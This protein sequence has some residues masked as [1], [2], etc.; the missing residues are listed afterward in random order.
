MVMPA[1][2]LQ[3]LAPLLATSPFAKRG[4]VVRGV[5][6]PTTTPSEWKLP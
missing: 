6:A 2:A 1:A 3:A 5:S 4:P